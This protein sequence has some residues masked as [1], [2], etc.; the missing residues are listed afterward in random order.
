MSWNGGAEVSRNILSSRD[1]QNE[2]R[3][4]M[5]SEPL[6]KREKALGVLPWS[7]RRQGCSAQANA[8][9]AVITVPTLP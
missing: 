4:W 2:L 8:L 3:S 5:W 9:H 6:D 7:L 1:T